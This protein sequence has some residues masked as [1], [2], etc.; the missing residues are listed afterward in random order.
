MKSPKSQEQERF[1]C[2]VTASEHYGKGDP[3]PM[4]SSGTQIPPNQGFHHPPDPVSVTA[5]QEML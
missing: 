5:R 4:P 1:F 2:Y 3:S